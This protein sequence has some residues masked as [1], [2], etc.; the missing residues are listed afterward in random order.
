MSTSRSKLCFVG[1]LAWVPA[2]G[3][4]P[5]VQGGVS[6]RLGGV[7]R[8]HLAALNLGTRSG[9]S[10]VRLA[11]NLSRLAAATGVAV[12]RAARIRLVHGTRLVEATGPGLAAD[13]DGVWTRAVGLPLALTVADC[14]PLLLAAAQGPI[15]LLHCGWRGLAAGIVTRAIAH[16]SEAAGTPPGSWWAWI[17]PGIGPCCFAAG[18]DVV[19]RFP[20]SAQCQTPSGERG[21]ASVDLPGFVRAELRA[22]GLAADQVQAADLCT[23]CEAPLFYS[24]RRDHGAT[25]RMLAWIARTSA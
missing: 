13:A 18:E 2:A 7:S 16:L 3:A 17:G 19:S 15:A 8:G 10:E 5:G 11:I 4:P 14:L 25:G 24:H 22:A 21:Q 9:D 20:L 12:D 23:S 6:T 1:D